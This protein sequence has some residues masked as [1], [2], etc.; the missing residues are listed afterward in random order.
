MRLLTF[1]VALILF[2]PCLSIAQQPEI[3]VGDGV[4]EIFETGAYIS[5]DSMSFVG[6][7]EEF[8]KVNRAGE[9]Y[10]N[11]ILTEDIKPDILRETI[12]KISNYLFVYQNNLE[13]NRQNSHIRSNGN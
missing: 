8:I 13:E 10:I 6:H 3:I 2:L 1:I 4:K 5:Y 9:I 11:G 7:G 12:I